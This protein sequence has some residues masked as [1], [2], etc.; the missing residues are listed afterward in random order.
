MAAEVE[1]TE[2]ERFEFGAGVEDREIRGTRGGL[3]NDGGAYQGG[4]AMREDT[5]G[6]LRGVEDPGV[7]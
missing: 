4:F 7:D 3:L 2:V 5:G 6:G 1:G